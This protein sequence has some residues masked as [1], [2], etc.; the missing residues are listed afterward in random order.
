MYWN[1]V[2]GL[3][4]NVLETTMN[5]QEFSTFRLVGGTALSLQM[6]HRISVDIDLFTDAPYGSLDLGALQ[7]FFRTQ[8]SY[9]SSGKG[10]P[11]FGE[12]YY[13][14]NSKHDSVKVD[15]YYTDTFKYPIVEKDKI[16]MASKEEICAMKLEV[17]GGGGRK[18]DFW[19]LHELA[20][21]YNLATMISFYKLR[22]PYGHE[23]DLIRAKLTDFDKADK[24]PDPECLLCK[25][26]EIVKLDLQNW[27]K[28]QMQ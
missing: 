14:G 26:W 9:V 16:R 21:H 11:V 19:D 1:T 8:Y 15:L 3:L 28:L 12:S 4:R 22:Y 25:H 7:D 10:L 5:S 23:E 24:D 6:G 2:N 20:D 13:V 17:V 18:K 27:L